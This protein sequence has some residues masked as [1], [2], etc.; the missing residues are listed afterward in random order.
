MIK[1]YLDKE[2]SLFRKFLVGIWILFLCVVLGAPLFVLSIKVDLFGLYGPMPSLASIENPENDLSSELLTRDGKS[3]GRYFVYNRSNVKFEGLSP[4]LVETLVASED[5]RFWDH[6]GLDFHAYV[7]AFAGIITFNPQGGGSTITQQLA[8]NLYT[9]NEQMGEELKGSIARTFGGITERLVQKLKEW[10]ISVRLEKNFTKKEILAMYLNTVPFR[11]GAFGIKTAAETYFNTTPDSLNIQESAVLVG[12]LQASTAFDPTYDFD[13][14]L[15]KR[16]QVIGKLRRF[17]EVFVN[18]DAALDSLRALEID[19]TNFSISNQNTGLAPYFRKVIAADLRKWC[20]ENGYNL[21]E[22]GLKVY[23]TIDYKLQKY[24]ELAVKEHLT[25]LQDRF[26]NEW[27][28]RKS[29]PWRN[30]RK[31]IRN[32]IEKR[33]QQTPRYRSLEKK[34]GKDH[35]S[36][37]VVLDKKYKMKVFTWKGEI[38]TLMSPMDSLAHYKYF[39]HTGF[40]AM[41]PSNGAILAWVGGIDHKYF[42]YDHVRQG[43]RQPGSI[44]KPFVYGTG[45]ENGFSPCYTMLDEQYRYTLPSG[46]VYSPNNA[47]GKFTGEDMTLRKAMAQSVNSVT[48]KLMSELGPPNV[49][50]FARRLGI[51]SQLDPVLALSL[52]T[53]DLSIFEL[54]PAYSTFANEG[55]YTTPFFITKIEDKNGNV[56][57]NFNPVTRQALS[58]E[59]AY[60]MLHMFKGGVEEQGG[61][62]VGIPRELKTNNEVGGKTGTTND[63]SDGWYIGLTHNL[64][65]GTWVGGDERSIQW[66]SW[67]YGQGA[68]TAR[69]IWEKFMLK[70]YADPESGIEKGFFKRPIKPLPYRLDCTDYLISEPSDSTNV[71]SDQTELRENEF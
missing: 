53:S 41:D 6:S 55:I 29:Q 64:V 51:K 26:N 60:L 22:D 46:D 54:L 17:S 1:K 14:A 70:V 69:P 43:R 3:L 45:M 48:V 63:A 39:L 36:I 7:R 61:T 15:G 47:D 50:E 33:I 9:Q 30:D 27:K 66:P 68:K 16:N 42:K 34:Y 11:H 44:F 37:D 18:S 8:K 13:R 56:I 67:V 4:E 2:N 31:Q 5:R 59:T 49:V 25:D 65:A 35:D 38:D 12:M 62:S 24:A 23:T 52:G 20:Q 40:M 32:Y 71:D 58:E 10:I 19:L 57:Q 21:Y 28:K